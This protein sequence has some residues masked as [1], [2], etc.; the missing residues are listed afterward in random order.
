MTFCDCQI[1]SSFTMRGLGFEP[2]VDNPL[3]W[4]DEAGDRVARFEQ[5]SFPVEKGFRSSAYYRQP[6]LWRWVCDERILQRALAENRVRVYWATESSNHVDQIKD[7]HD[8][9]EFNEKKSP[10][11]KELEQ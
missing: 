4:V 6:R 3:I 11:E 1:F 8:M 10:F 5:F 9:I 7:R 2:R